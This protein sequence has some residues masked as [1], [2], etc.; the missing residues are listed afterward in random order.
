MGNSIASAKYWVTAEPTGKLPFPTYVLEVRQHLPAEVGGGV[1][2]MR[3]HE[4]LQLHGRVLELYEGQPQPPLQR[5]QRPLQLV[6]RAH[7]Q[8]D[9]HTHVHCTSA[10]TAP[11]SIY[12]I[13][14]A[15]IHE[16]GTNDTCHVL[17]HVVTQPRTM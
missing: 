7:G 14:I 6:G 5:A 16:Q 10:R 11:A 17:Q 1:E 4:G 2:D 9:L 13:Y 8:P 3:A 15:V 12:V